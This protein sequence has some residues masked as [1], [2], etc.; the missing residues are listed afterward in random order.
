MVFNMNIVIFTYF[1][2]GNLKSLAFVIFSYSLAEHWAQGTYDKIL[3][4]QL[5]ISILFACLL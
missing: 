3:C 2:K 1:K 4:Q 5:G